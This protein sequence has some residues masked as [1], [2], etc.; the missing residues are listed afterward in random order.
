MSSLPLL[1]AVE[2]MFSPEYEEAM[3]YWIDSA[4]CKLKLAIVA[5]ML[6]YSLPTAYQCYRL[7][8]G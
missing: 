7:Y 8:M 1:L 6:A 3:L 4:L 5:G 2:D